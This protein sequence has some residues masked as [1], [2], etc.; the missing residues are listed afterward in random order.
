MATKNPSKTAT[1]KSDQRTITAAARKPPQS[2]LSK[3]K[4][5]TVPAE[6]GKAIDAIARK[7][8]A[9]DADIQLAAMSAIC[10]CEKHGDTTF[11]NR[12]YLALGKGARKRALADWLLNFGRVSVNVD[13]ATNKEQPFSY[14]KSKRTHA[15]EAAQTPWYDFAP[16]G[17]VEEMFDVRAALHRII[18][19][20]SKAGEV[21]D[22]ELLGRLRE[23]DDHVSAGLNVTPT[24]PAAAEQAAAAAIH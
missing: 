13:K 23:I 6:L 1:K 4:L 20:A 21:N 12:L 24:G 5:I 16:E 22:P 9:I 7:S 14:D 17:T 19:K 10:H 8:K 15:E 11:I 3:L 2:A 18:Q